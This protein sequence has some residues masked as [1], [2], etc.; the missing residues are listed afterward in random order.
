MP[1]KTAPKPPQ[2]DEAVKRATGRDW[3]AWIAW[4]DARGGRELDHKGLV[5][6]LKDEVESGWWRQSVAVGYEQLAQGRKV[7]ERPDGYQVQASKTINAPIEKVWESVCPKGLCDWAPPGALAPSTEVKPE[8]LRGAWTDGGKKEGGVG[9]ARFGAMLT[10][11]PG[12]KTRLTVQL[13]RIS[14]AAA[15]EKAKAAW[16]AALADLK[17]RLEG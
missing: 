12:G 3:K 10:T 13:G 6:A 15:A 16:R 7:N 14:D 1:E 2:S 11:A 9:S 17:E 4:L 8:R 5:A